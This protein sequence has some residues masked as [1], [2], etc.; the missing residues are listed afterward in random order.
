M[1]TSRWIRFAAV[2]VVSLAGVAAADVE[3]HPLFRD[4]MVL[5]RQAK[6]PVWGKASSGEKV[7]VSMLGNRAEAVADAAGRWRVE[8][9]P[10]QAGGPFE[11]TVQGENTITVKDVARRRGVGVQRPVEHGLAG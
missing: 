8:I 6:V 11:M 2:Y 1:I 5:Q 4:H 7:S 10:F 9:G 3:L